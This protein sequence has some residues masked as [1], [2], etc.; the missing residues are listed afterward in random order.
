MIIPQD[1]RLRLDRERLKQHRKR[2]GLSQEAL[3]EYCFDRRLCVSIASIKRAESGKAVLY[4]TARHLAEIYEVEVEELS[5]EAEEAA[6][7][8]SDIEEMERARVLIQLHAVAADPSALASWV[9]HFGGS[10]EEGGTALFGLPRAYRSDA[11]RGLLCAATLV[12]QGVARGVYLQAGHWPTDTPLSMSGEQSGVWVERGVAVQLAERFVFDDEGGEWLHYRRPRD[13]A[14]EARFDLV[15]RRVEL[16]QLQAI[17]ESTRAYQ[18]GHLVYIRGVAGIGKTRL[19]AEFAEMAAAHADHHQA[20]VLDFGTRADEGPL[21]QLT[22]SLLQTSGEAQGE[23]KGEAQGDAID[24][25]Q[26]LARLS[27]LRLPVDHAML[28]RPLLGLAQPEEAQSLYAAMAPATRSQR[29]VQALRDVLLARSIH[30][31]QLVVVEDLHWADEALL[32]T[33]TGLLQET[34]DAPVIWLFTSR[35]EQDPLETRLRPQLPELPLTLIELPPL[36][37]QEAE[38]LVASFGTV[39]AEHAARCVTQAQ[40]N[41]LFLTQL[42]LFHPHRSL[43]ASLANLVQTKLDQLTDLDRRAMCIAA[44]MGQ[45]F[46]LASL[47]EVLG[48]AD[49][50]P[51][52][53]QR[54]SLV[55][56]LEEGSYRFVHDLILQGIYEGI[57]K[58]Q[59]DRLHLRLAELYG[60]AEPGLRARHLHR[61]RS[62]EAPNAFL[63][64]VAAEMGRYRHEEALALLKQCRSIDYAPKDEYR[65]M[66][67]QGQV[68]MA[69]GHIQAAREHFEA[70]RAFARE[71]G[72][73]ISADLWLA[74]VL[75]MLDALA[76]EEAILDGL[77]PLAEALEDPLP[78]AEALYLKG[79]LYFP[80]GDFATSRAY[81]TRA[82]EQARRGGGVRTEI[83]ALS[84]LGDAHYAEGQMRST[85]ELFDHCVT[86]CRTHGHADLEAS[87]LFML[88]TARIYANQTEAALA[89]CFDAAELGKRVGNRRAEVVAR[90]TAG[91][92]LISQGDPQAA[93]EQI[94]QALTVARGLGSGRFEAFLLESRARVELITGRLAEARASIERA[95]QLVEQHGLKAFIGP[96]VLGTRALLEEEP[97]A[98]LATL[99]QGEALLDA[100]C[101]GH[102][103]YRFLIAA[104]EVSLLDQRPDAARHYAQRLTQ[105]MA[106][107][108]CAWGEH[109]R[110][111]IEA[112]ADWLESG[113]AGG[114][115]GSEAS[116]LEALRACWHRGEAAGLVMTLPR[117]AASRR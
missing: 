100:G 72:Q 36:R 76:A 13:E 94:E 115:K 71:E 111:L 109:H 106:A 12:E 82:L 107:E 75:N 38:A 20:E 64:A 22:R 29:L 96:W 97:E 45:R 23:A 90:L 57:P 89:D 39:P 86:L 11:Q 56:P 84:G 47:Q 15:G 112:H 26:L 117:L 108:P 79:N 21:M 59:R 1:G 41:P 18:A 6:V 52:L 73:R 3:A 24:E 19:S 83:Q 68:A 48:Q 88:G 92:I 9:Q 98:R 43:P 44:V 81:H 10:L 46:S 35:L 77:L 116:T 87:N 99:Q 30:R 4:R 70:A 31:P 62:L 16:G 74:R 40:G 93:D 114:D 110:A 113:Q 104:A 105:L 85:L 61:A 102:N 2:L 37:A 25:A 80:R 14:H 63:Q 54:Y 67:L 42:L 91:W 49:Y 28:L 60:E 27:A 103:G 53:P 8:A 32:A 65:L 95:W 78:L 33:L 58:I 7:V 5:A 50:Q 17:L 55:R 101:V 66:L 69:T 34:Q 51:E